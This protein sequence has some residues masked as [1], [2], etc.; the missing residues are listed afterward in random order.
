MNWGT[1]VRGFKNEDWENYRNMLLDTYPQ[2][3]AKINHQHAARQA[4]IGLSAAMIAAAFEEVDCTP[5]EGFD[6]DALDDIPSLRARGLRGEG[7][8]YPNPPSPRS[9][10]SA[11]DK[12][13][14][15]S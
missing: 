4:Y 8:S 15:R 12:I 6:S 14:T 11:P 5:M 2:R 1:A 13:A 7:S 9:R 10:K 3:D